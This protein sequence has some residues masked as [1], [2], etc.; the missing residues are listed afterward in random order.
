MLRIFIK[1]KETKLFISL[2]IFSVILITLNT[3]LKEFSLRSIIRRIFLPVQYLHMKIFSLF[4]DIKLGIK[5]VS[6]LAYENKL[7]KEKIWHLTKEK[8]ILEKI[9]A[10]NRRLKKIMDY[11]MKLP[12]GS[13]SAKVV[14]MD[15]GNLFKVITINK[16]SRNG[17]KEGME[18]VTFIDDK[19][20]LVGR[21]IEVDKDSSQVLLLLD[22]NSELGV[23]IPRSGVNAILV[24]N[25]HS[26]RLKYVEK[27]A[28]VKIGD[29]VVTSGMGGVFSKGFILGKV[30]KINK[31]KLD[32]FYEIE[33]TP[34]LDQNKLEEVLVVVNK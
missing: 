17:I 12:H 32:L 4:K 14:A 29:K 18:V 8:E 25:N 1:H 15:P 2:L 16:G 30:S 5:E 33:V 7:L 6:R 10:E 26:Y 34:T 9:L 21:T 27:D 3:S 31:D 24:G 20:E 11:K 22:Q 23:Y 28:D 19:E 13:V